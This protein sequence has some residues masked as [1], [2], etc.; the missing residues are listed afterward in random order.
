MESIELDRGWLARQMHEV[1]QEVR[2]WPDVM[3]PLR[4]LN[5]SLVHRTNVAE[6]SI[7]PRF[8]RSTSTEIPE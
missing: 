5:S 3:M 8:N 1:R 6:C 4:T 2:N 7:D